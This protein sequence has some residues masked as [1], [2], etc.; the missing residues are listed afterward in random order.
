MRS[1]RFSLLYFRPEESR[2]VSGGLRRLLSEFPL[3]NLNVG[4]GGA[5]MGL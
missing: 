4:A 3:V 5:Q 2:L 1:R